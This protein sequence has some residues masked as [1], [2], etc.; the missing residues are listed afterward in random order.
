MQIKATRYHYTAIRI[1]K[2]QTLT[3]LDAGE[4]AKQQE[5]SFIA[6][7]NVKWYNSERQL[8]RFLQN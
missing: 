2:N 4:N 5:L 1:T 8:H 3:T 7:S 6:T